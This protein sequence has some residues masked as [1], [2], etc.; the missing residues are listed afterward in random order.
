MTEKQGDSANPDTGALLSGAELLALIARF[1]RTTLHP[2]IPSGRKYPRFNVEAIKELLD[3][4]GEPWQEQRYSHELSRY[5]A[6]VR[7]AFVSSIVTALLLYLLS[8]KWDLQVDADAEEYYERIVLTLLVVIPVIAWRL[9]SGRT[10]R[11]FFTSIGWAISAI[12]AA[13]RQ[14]NYGWFRFKPLHEGGLAETLNATGRA[15]KFLFTSLQ[16]SR[17]TWQGPPTVAERAIRLTRPLIDIELIDELDVSH[18]GDFTK[19]LML[20]F[21]LQDVAAVVALRREDLIPRVRDLY[22][23]LPRR[24]SDDDEP[25][26]RDVRFLDPMNERSRWDVIKD[27]IIPLSSWLSLTVAIGALI[28]S[29]MK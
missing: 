13:R 6:S 29:I 22:I 24:P 28:L 17:L 14:E 15:A 25:R 7:L 23:E 16:R 5:R 8:L 19:R 27:Y 9:R 4:L 20:Q 21:F 10:R 18:G 3:K 12:D 26:K 1:P 2:R 11:R